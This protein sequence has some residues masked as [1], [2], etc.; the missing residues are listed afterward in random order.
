MVSEYTCYEY[1]ISNSYTDGDIMN[2]PLLP[3]PD[4][5]LVTITDFTATYECLPNYSLSGDADR[6][7]DFKTGVWSGDAPLCV[8]KLFYT[9]VY[10]HRRF[11][12]VSA[13]RK[14]VTFTT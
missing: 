7:C 8:S 10:T 2:C 9:F 1:I 6:A 12:A 5:G 13:F 4:N 11:Y 3:N 14:Y